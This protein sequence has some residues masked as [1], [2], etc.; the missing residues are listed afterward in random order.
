MTDRTAVVVGGNRIPFARAHSA[1]RH[2][3]NIDML[4]AALDGLAA[5]F[6]L[7]GHSRR[8]GRGRRSPQAQPRL[9]PHP[10]GGAGLLA[11]PAQ[12]RVRP[13]A[14]VRDRARSHDLREQQD[15]P[16]PDRGRHRRR[17]GQRLRRSHGGLGR[18]APG[19]PR[20]QLREDSAG[21]ARCAV[22]DT[23]EPPR[24]RP[25]RRHRAP[26]RPVDGRAPGADHGALGNHPPGA[27]RVR[28]G[29][30]PEP[31]SCLE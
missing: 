5:R 27:G 13:A 21:Q 4:T 22:V 17:R 1:Y 26:H 10:R 18:A 9:Q 3:S 30:P 28:A 20:G 29:E 12:S 14:G 16:R 6:G 24:P 7:A 23:A 19:A 25:A 15:P 8:R 31:G 11:R 2:A